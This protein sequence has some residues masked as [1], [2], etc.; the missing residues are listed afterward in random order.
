M[1]ASD[2]IL[3]RRTL[4]NRIWSALDHTENT[5]YS[6]FVHRKAHLSGYGDVIEPFSCSSG[7][8]PMRLCRPAASALLFASLRRRDKPAAT[9]IVRFGRNVGAPT[10]TAQA[11]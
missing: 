11:G 3:L 9:Q 1:A 2:N 10:K 4:V 7:F 6:S 5:G 8:M